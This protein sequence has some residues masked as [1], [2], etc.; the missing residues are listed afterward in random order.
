MKNGHVSNHEINFKVP[1]RWTMIW[2]RRIQKDWS[3][4]NPEAE[5][6]SQVKA[7]RDLK[8]SEGNDVPVLWILGS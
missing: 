7:M 8:P 6:D 5:S 3:Q 1:N 4:N 2:P